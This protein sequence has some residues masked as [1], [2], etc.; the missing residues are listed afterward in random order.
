MVAQNWGSLVLFW[1]LI[2]KNAKINLREIFGK[3]QKCIHAKIY[4]TY[5]PGH[6][7][8][9]CAFAMVC[10]KGDAMPKN[11]M[12]CAAIESSTCLIL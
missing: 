8:R 10:S 9:C 4:S 11:R 6:T 12:R 1:V 3:A 7:L 2:L 5:R